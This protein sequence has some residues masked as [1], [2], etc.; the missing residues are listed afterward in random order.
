MV[1]LKQTI[2]KRLLALVLSAVMIFG[3]APFSALAVG[4]DTAL[5]SG[6]AFQ[7]YFG[8]QLSGQEN[9]D[10]T[11]DVNAAVFYDSMVQLYTNGNMKKGNISM[12]VSADYSAPVSELIV[13]KD[14]AKISQADLKDYA[15]NGNPA[16]LHSLQAARDAF[17][18]DYPELFYVDFNKL[19]LKLGRAE[20]DGSY[21]Y[22]AVIGNG[23]YDNYYAGFTSENEVNSALAEVDA[24]L[25]A[26]VTS[27][28]K[29]GSTIASRVASIHDQI[30]KKVTYTFADTD[31]AKI[32]PYINDIYG[33]LIKGRALCEGYA[34]TFK[35]AMDKLKIPC[36]LVSG[37]G[38]REINDNPSDVEG[39]MWAYVQMDDGNWY[40]VD[41]TYDDPVKKIANA[42]GSYTFTDALEFGRSLYLLKGSDSFHANHTYSGIFS[43]GGRTFAYPPLNYNDYLRYG[44]EGA[45][46]KLMVDLYSTEDLPDEDNPNAL[47]SYTRFRVL[48]DGMTPTQLLDKNGWDIVVRCKVNG[49]MSVWMPLTA[50][51]D[52]EMLQGVAV[53]QASEV[54]TSDYQFAVV[55]HEVNDFKPIPEAEIVA[56]SDTYQIRNEYVLERRPW[57]MEITPS[58]SHSLEGEGP[59]RCKFVYDA[60]LHK[61]DDSKPVEMGV[62]TNYSNPN[63]KIN[64]FT[65]K[66]EMQ[67]GK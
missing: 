46:R 55:N 65:W 17:M 2:T 7:G 3:M 56:I 5:S 36:V 53:I 30:I 54:P 28:T 18:Y 16:L 40:A 4:S 31:D 11:P 1:M 57:P 9:P 43:Q 13:E 44:Q 8:K 61:A 45:D 23:S 66:N 38:L 59:F 29:P 19:G 33:A 51:A 50:F 48:Y 21:K 15:E 64:N 39:H 35:A 41:V 6:S 67:D 47:V 49:V 10:G 60:P 32:K 24:A 34:R 25:N 37:G 26:M 42:D 63:Y 27:A 58:S 20:S 12:N 22:F 14:G 52:S 62:E